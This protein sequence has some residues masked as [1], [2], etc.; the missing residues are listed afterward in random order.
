[1]PISK[2]SRHLFAQSVHLGF[3]FED[4]HVVTNL[5]VRRQ[6]DG[7]SGVLLDAFGGTLEFGMLGKRGQRQLG[8]QQLEPPNDF[9]KSGMQVP[10]SAVG[11]MR[12]TGEHATCARSLHQA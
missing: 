6:G 5:A 12:H 7:G 1:M 4:L 9:L 8:R 3:L 11:P 10:F 2:R